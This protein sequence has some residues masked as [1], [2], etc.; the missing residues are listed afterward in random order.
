MKAADFFTT[1][2]AI[3]EVCVSEFDYF[4]VLQAVSRTTYQSLYV[5]DYYKQRFEFVSENPLFLCGQSAEE[6][7]NLG[8]EFYLRRVPEEDLKLLLKI[9]E[10]GFKFYES[11]PLKERKS[12]SITYDFH[13]VNEFGKQILVNHKYT[14]VY[15]TEEGKIWK[16]LCI[17]SLST[18][19]K[20]GNIII[21]KDNSNEIWKY[22]PESEKWV[23]EQ[24]ITLSAKEKEVLI[25]FSQGY[26]IKEI[27]EKLF[28]SQDTIKFYRRKMFDKMEVSNI[29]EALGFAIANKV[30]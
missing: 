19:T 23:A 24:K 20:S 10:V 27:S 11:L 26:S 2:N 17:F 29:S 9:N 22:N 5:I 15:L 21:T 13:I 30:I 14:P 6:F 1:I 3:G 25:L 18:N 28:V 8:Y 7:K 4:E 12:Y 16:A